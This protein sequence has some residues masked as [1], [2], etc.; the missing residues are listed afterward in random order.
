[1]LPDLRAVRLGEMP[2][3]EPEALAKVIQ[4]VLPRDAAETVTLGTA[5]ASGI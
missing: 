1:M 4:R 5:F 2:A 3:L